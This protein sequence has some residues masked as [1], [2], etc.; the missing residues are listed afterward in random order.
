MNLTRTTVA[1]LVGAGVV[2]GAAGALVTSRTGEP[3]APAPASV[4]G[5]VV[6]ESEGVVTPTPAAPRPEA[7]VAPVVRPAPVA[8][9]APAPAP[10]PQP[11]PPSPA[12]TAAPAPV[13]VAPPAPIAPL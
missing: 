6:E 7:P 1:I 2:A 9:R 8:R 13:A 11:A 4:P 5:P 10:R 12:A 3:A